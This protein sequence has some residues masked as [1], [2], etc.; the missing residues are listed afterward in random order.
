MDIKRSKALEE[1]LSPHDISEVM[2]L[3]LHTSTCTTGYHNDGSTGYEIFMN[4]LELGVQTEMGYEI[5]E[6]HDDGVALFF[7]AQHEAGLLKELRPAIE[8][9]FKQ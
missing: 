7:V 4:G 8:E 3:D 1:L 2:D 5:F 9:A 6:Y